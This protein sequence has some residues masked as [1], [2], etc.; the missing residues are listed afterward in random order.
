MGHWLNLFHLWGTANGSTTCETDFVDDTP[1]QK[2]SN[3][4]CP[5][6]PRLANCNPADPSVMFMNYMDYTDDNCMNLFT[7]GQ[8]Q[9][10]RAIF[11]TGGP[12]AGQLNGFFGASGTQA[13]IFC[14]GKVAVSGM[15]VAATWTLVSGPATITAGQ[16]TNQITLQA[17]GNGVV[18]LR[19][20]AGNYTSGDVSVTVY[21]S[22]PALSISS[23]TNGCNGAY[24]QWN[25]VNETPTYGSNWMWSVSLLSTPT[26]QITINTPSAPSTTLSVK[27]GG[28]VRLNYTDICGV[29]RTSGITVY[30]TC[31]GF[32]AVV[33][34]NPVQ[35]NI[36]IS[37]NTTA[38]ST[39]TPEE[40]QVSPIRVLESKGKT[41]MTLFEVNTNTLAKQWTHPESI[42]KN[43]NLNTNGL[44]KGVYVLQIDRDNQTT[45][46]KIIIQ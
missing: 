14:T 19:A 34:P 22:G 15:C 44:R 46:T 20:T 9:R 41:I 11:A 8:K 42:N 32:S 28:A 40:T 23:T 16:G 36:N 7:N 39:S 31:F 18:V 17:T 4:G 13:P 1:A 6:Y 38:N 37:L 30:S 33:S 2:F 12:R 3:Q 45:V 29:A 5:A 25:I 35:N 10:A 26:S 24:Q 43:Y 21:T 27:G